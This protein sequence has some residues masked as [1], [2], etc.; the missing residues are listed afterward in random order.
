M[1]EE[2][3]PNWLRALN[4]ITG[5]VAI[6]LGI[7]VLLIPSVAV[8]TLVF[9]LYIALMVIGF[10]R[11]LVGA[12]AGF[13]SGGLRAVSIIAGLIAFAVAV[14]ALVYPNFAVALLVT[15]FGA[16]LLLFG[17]GRVI[18]G[19]MAK[20]LANWVRALMII[21]G[22]LTIGLSI[23]VLIFPGVA[24]LTLVFLLSFALVWNGI[25]TVV[26]GVTGAP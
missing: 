7:V 23:A 3:A 20:I 21:G 24:I 26:S 4:I 6:I 15:L 19:V 18:I 17:L 25:D 2:E 8:E 22:F 16:T 12:L 5:L 14:L 9:L 1:A 11:I 13:L 10:G